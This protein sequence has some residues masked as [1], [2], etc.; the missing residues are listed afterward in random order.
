MLFS[1]INF[2]RI[3]LNSL[4]VGG[5]SCST[6][7]IG[8]MYLKALKTYFHDQLIILSSF[9]LH[10][11]T[12][13]EQFWLFHERFSVYFCFICELG[14]QAQLEKGD[15]TDLCAPIRI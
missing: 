12:K 9:V 5:C 14:G 4:Q 7:T 13:Y 15:V 1:C 3:P 2:L 8:Y 10:E 6:R 11:H